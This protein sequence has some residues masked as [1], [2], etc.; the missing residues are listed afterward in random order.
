MNG[1]TLALDLCNEDLKSLFFVVSYTSPTLH[2][3][4]HLERTRKLFPHD[5]LSPGV[6]LPVSSAFYDH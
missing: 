6:V 1:S 4:H 2:I 5:K 3:L